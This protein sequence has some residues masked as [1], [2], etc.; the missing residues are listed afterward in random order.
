M[1][2]TPSSSNRRVALRLVVG[3]FVAFIASI[4]IASAAGAVITGVDVA[5][6]Q[7]PGT[8]NW[9]SAENAPCIGPIDWLQVHSAGHTYA[10][11]KATGG[12]GYTNPCFAQ[13]WA[14]ITAADLYRGAYHWAKPASPAVDQARYF[15]SRTGSMTGAKDLPGFLDLEETG[16][17]GRRELAQWTRDFLSEVTRLTGKKPMLYV[18][19]YFWS[20]NLGSA[21]DI[22]EQYRLWLPDYHCQ[23]QSGALLCDPNTNS[24]S[25][26]GFDGWTR[27][28]FWQNYSVG[29]VP[30]IVGN[31]D[32]SRF[33]C[34]LGSLAALAGAGAG[35]GSPFG[36]FDGIA[37][38][39]NNSVHVWGWAIDPDTTSPIAIH[40]YTD[41]AWTGS[42]TANVD[43][44]DVGAGYLGFG[45]AHGFSADFA[46]PT[47]AQQICAYGINVSSGANT[48]LRCVSLGGAPIGSFD[49][50][51]VTRP[52]KVAVAG[53]AADPN[54]WTRSTVVHVYAGS[55]WTSL[56]AN[57]SRA[58]V[59]NALGIGGNHGFS[60]EVDAS[61]G[62][63][64]VCLYGIND[65]GPGGPSL[66]SCK[67]VTVPTGS[68]Y[69][70]LD[71]VNPRVGAIDFA[72][73]VIDPDT[74][75]PTQV[76]VYVDGVGVA[77]LAS[78]Y[79]SDLAAI[80]PMYGGNHGFSTSIPVA[81]GSHQVCVYSINAFGAG[82]NQTM[83]CRTV[84]TPDGSPFGS[85]D[86]AGSGF[87]LI[88]VSGWALDPDTS[89]PIV[90]H[91]YVNGVGVGMIAGG[92]RADVAA[93]FG[94]G[95]DHGF[96]YVAPRASAAA[97]TI[98]VFGLNVG[99]GANALIGCRVV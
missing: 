96:S 4:A 25:P 52:G 56:P 44:S 60:A 79:R 63:I 37:L 75:S 71:A 76:H 51:A 32:M 66:L 23:A 41:G 8:S 59:N 64:Q 68:P 83:G 28:T 21:S 38:N 53:W 72:G 85:I 73:W 87:G 97:Q 98:C 95:P 40:F 91:V 69:G 27:W 46:I 31:V 36:S 89:N 65:T 55:A 20:D 11:V 35:A 12:T 47:G 82:S 78:G 86:W 50:V 81:G 84:V 99:S 77:V 70:S 3:F 67:S 26:P 24:Y 6:W 88:G 80:F 61:G 15:V 48:Q 19:R 74:A 39:S 94:H 14:G 16:G 22:G 10:Y 13:D 7:H 58:D 17:L 30:G 54:D 90:I 57:Q 93:A 2:D 5:S 49:G 92:P 34:D 29:A 33:C 1:T 43:R 45:A 62:P 9:L 18:G 42:A